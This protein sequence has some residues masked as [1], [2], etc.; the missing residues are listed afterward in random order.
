MLVLLGRDHYHFNKMN[1]KPQTQE[2]CPE[3]HPEKWDGKT[4]IWE[5]RKFVKDSLPTLF[6]IPFPPTIG[7]KITRMWKSIESSGSAEPDKTGTLVLFH[8]PSAF[9]SDILIS[10]EKEVPGENNV[11]MSGNFISRTFDGEY[12]DIPKFIRVMDKYLAETGKKAKDY[13]VHYAYC[14]KCAKKFGHNYMILFAE[15]QNN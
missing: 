14:P 2:C 3:F 5:S 11:A 13:Y 9:R 15:V 7:R 8:D 10:V 1:T 4:H 6:H 12:N